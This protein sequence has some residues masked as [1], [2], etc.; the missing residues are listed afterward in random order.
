MIY[1]LIEFGKW[2]SDNRL[3]DFGKT[4]HDTDMFLK[5]NYKNGNF[6]LNENF[7][8]KENLNSEFYEKSIFS[9]EPLFPPKPVQNYSLPNNNALTGFSPF[10]IKLSDNKKKNINKIE[11]SLNAHFDNKKKLSKKIV[12]GI[13]F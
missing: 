2:L 9:N 11:R 8:F 5:V 4:I 3:D 12:C 6:T 13:K 1:D 7:E 10:L